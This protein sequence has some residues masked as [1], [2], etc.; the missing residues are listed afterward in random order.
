[1][2]NFFFSDDICNEQGMGNTTLCPLCDQVCNYM[3][4]SESCHYSKLSYVFDN[5][6]TV[7][8]AVFMSFW[9]K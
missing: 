1:M 6:A 2:L 8:F 4:L 5:P 7:I 3:K 9:G